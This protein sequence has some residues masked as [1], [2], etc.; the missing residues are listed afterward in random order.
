LGYYSCRNGALLA[1]RER[2]LS[3]TTGQWLTVDELWP[4]EHP[5]AY[6]DGSPAS[7]TDRF[8]RQKDDPIETSIKQ[9]LGKG[10]KE[11][12]QWM[13]AVLADAGITPPPGLAS[14][15]ADYCKSHPG[16]YV[17]VPNDGKSP[18]PH[19][20]ICTTAP[21]GGMGHVEITDAECW[22][23]SASHKKRSGKKVK[24]LKPGEPIHDLD[25]SRHGTITVWRLKPRKK[26]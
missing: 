24:R 23:V 8:G 10:P 15:W 18:G 26:C 17:S 13:Q 2:T 19:C 14:T 9:H 22:R 1:A 4:D 7:C 6:V 3:D 25:P 5:Y 11:C 12:N 16:V 20:L 21:G